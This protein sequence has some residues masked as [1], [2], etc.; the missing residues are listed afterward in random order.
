ML[1]DHFGWIQSPGEL[2]GAFRRGA[3]CSLQVQHVET[4]EQF[5]H[6]AK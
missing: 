5:N 6:G 1:A 3:A 2:G 4:I